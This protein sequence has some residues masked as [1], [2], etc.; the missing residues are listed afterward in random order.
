MVSSNKYF[1][2]LG[3][4]IQHLIDNNYFKKINKTN[5]LLS[6]DF[7]MFNQYMFCQDKQIAKLICE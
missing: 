6:C 5:I 3:I 7:N 1:G 4:K 2:R